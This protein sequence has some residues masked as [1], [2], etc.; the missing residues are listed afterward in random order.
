RTYGMHFID[1]FP[2]RELGIAYYRTGNLSAA[3][4]ELEVSISQFSTAKA[5]FY[6]DRVRKGMVERPGQVVS[7]PTLKL[8]LKEDEVWTRDHPVVIS[9]SAE[10]EH[11][12]AGI[13]IGDNPLYMEGSKKRVTFKES[14]DLPQG[15]H[16]IEVEATNLPGMAA[17]RRLVIH[18]DRQGP[19][20]TVEELQVTGPEIG[21]SGSIYDEAGVSGLEINGEKVQIQ[22]GQDV[23]FSKK[24]TVR[25][26]TI[27]LVALDD[28]GNRTEAVIDLGSVSAGREPVLLASAESE[29]PSIALAALFGDKDTEPPHIA[30]RGFTDSQTVFLERVYLDGQA[31][32]VGKVES[33]TIN[34][35]PI[36]RRKGERVFFSHVAELKVGE[37]TIHIEAKDVAG[38]TASQRI[39]VIRHIPKAL[40]LAERLSLTVLPFEQKGT[41][42]DVSL[43]LQD[44]LTDAMVNENRFRVV[45]RDKLELVLREQKLSRSKLIDKS[46]AISLGKLVATQT[47]ITGSIIET[48]AGIEVVGRMID[49]ETSEILATVDVYDEIKDIPGLRTLGEG[50][51]IKFH[52][53]FPLLDGLV[54][55]K[56]GKYIFTDLGQDKVGTHMRFIV[57]RE[58]PIR[59]PVTK[60]ILG[61]DNEIIGQAR[62][63]QVM[64]QMSKAEMTGGKAERV[65]RQCKVITQ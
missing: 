62:V 39:T 8:G 55:Q 22:K 16:T 57:Y 48:R 52:R 14:L 65:T 1:Y 50:M 17:K 61:A 53:H 19:I 32:D 51:A 49:T 11:Y 13:S 4:K 24:L 15:R 27:E 26:D 29:L 42:S 59:H 37:N 60:K 2:H 38:N 18:V 34:R 41:V 56:K 63:I 54:V 64:P 33:L 28:L 43:S 40:Q 21:I 3:K 46:T 12:V 36:L 45:E 47:I 20:V 31:S 7:P 5:L 44:N 6:L 9:G 35:V 25:A 30:L 23:P 10:D 58:Y